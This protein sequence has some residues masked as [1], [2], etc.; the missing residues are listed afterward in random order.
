[1][2]NS[3]NKYILILT[4]L[5]HLCAL[6]PSLYYNKIYYNISVFYNIIILFATLFS[7]LWHLDESNKIIM[8]IDYLL[9]FLWLILDIYIALLNYILLLQI[10]LLNFI[11]FFLNILIKKNNMYYIYHSIWHI[12]SSIKCLYIIYLFNK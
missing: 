4:A 11:I 2:I 6:Y 5:L 1:M 3:Y 12:Q 7:M 9:A 10:L 8:Y